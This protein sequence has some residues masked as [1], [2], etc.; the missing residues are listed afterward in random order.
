MGVTAEQVAV[1]LNAP[2]V[3]FWRNVGDSLEL[4]IE[5]NIVEAT[6]VERNDAD[7]EFNQ[8]VWFTI[9]ID[10]QYFRRYGRYQ[11]HYGADWDYGET[12]EVFPETKVITGF[13]PA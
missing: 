6:V 9:Q 13:Y 10:E 5:G 7:D 8:R 3:P 4:N 11:S 12:V 2:G 1:A